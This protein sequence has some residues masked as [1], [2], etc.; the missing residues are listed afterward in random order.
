MG[1]ASLYAD[2]E[3]PFVLKQAKTL[4]MEE[5]ED[6]YNYMDVNRPQ[7]ILEFGTQ[8]GCST[9]VFLE[10]S[11]W[12][13]YKVDVHS[14]D[15]IDSVQARCVS[16]Q[17]FTFHLE[18]MEGKEKEMFDLYKPDF[19][20][21]DAHAYG[22]TR[23]IMQECLKRK[24]SFAAHDIYLP[25]FEE[26][27]KLTKNFTDFSVYVNWEIYLL[28]DLISKTLWEVDSYEDEFVRVDCTRKPGGYGLAIIKVKEG[29][30]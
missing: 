16:K 5:C 21:L 22:M 2:S 29:R 3:L 11:K 27:K 17:N 25:A 26:S 20:F 14:W 18:N 12:L 30:N 15:I 10:I 24:V 4:S 23:K 28:G 9:R 7:T 1:F 19:L 8:Y 6:I 13:D